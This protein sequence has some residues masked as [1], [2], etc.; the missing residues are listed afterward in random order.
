MNDNTTS[1]N[2]NKL[3]DLLTAVFLLDPEQFRFET[4]REEVET[5]DSLGVVSLAVGIQDTFGIH[6]KPE[7]ALSLKSFQQI[8]AVLSE[9][10][11]SFAA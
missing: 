3:R 9:K 7:E 1:D 5:W 2:R 6:L 11:V 4:T 8:I 10:G